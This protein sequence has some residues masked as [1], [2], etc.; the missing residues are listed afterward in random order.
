MLEFLKMVL[1][2][3]GACLALAWIGSGQRTRRRKRDGGDLPDDAPVDD[4]SE[5]GA[6]GGFLGGELEDVFVGRFALRR[7]RGGKD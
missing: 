3:G 1:Y 4:M 5:I 2:L 7:R 6:A